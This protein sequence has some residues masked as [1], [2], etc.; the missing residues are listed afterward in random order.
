MIRSACPDSGLG[1]TEYRLTHLDCRAHVHS[2][3]VRARKSV[4]PAILSTLD[5]ADEQA[6]LPRGTLSTCKCC[7]GRPRRARRRVC[8]GASLLVRLDSAGLAGD[9]AAE[10]VVAL[11]AAHQQ[12]HVVASLTL[13]QVLFEHLH[14]C[15]RRGPIAS[16]AQLL[17]PLHDPDDC[18]A[19]TLASC[20]GLHVTSLHGTLCL[21]VAGL[22]DPMRTDRLS[23]VGI[24]KQMSGHACDDSLGG[25]ALHAHQ[26]DVL[27]DLDNALL[28]AA[29]DDGATALRHPHPYP[30][31]TRVQPAARVCPLPLTP[32]VS[33]ADADGEGLL[34]AST[35]SAAP[36]RRACRLSK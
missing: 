15:A 36:E 32:F 23:L 18:Y 21:F 30:H 29:R 7:G 19:E 14:A 20:S 13:R 8:C 28:N 1:H 25:N 11:D 17:R 22:Y 5:A 2:W 24:G 10:H 34:P 12:P 4:R 31:P 6:V 33:V 35:L 16:S 3:S 27:P 9:L 26:L